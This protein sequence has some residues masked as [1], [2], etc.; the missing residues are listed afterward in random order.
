M[1]KKE[2][3]EYIN[4]AIEAA[5]DDNPVTREQLVMELIPMGVKISTAMH[6]IT[7]AFKKAGIITAPKP[8]ALKEVKEWLEKKMPEIDTYRDMRLLAEKL[9]EKFEVNDDDE[10]AVAAIIK[11]IQ[12][13]LK[14]EELPIPRR[15]NLGETKALTLDYFQWCDDEDE[16]ATKDGL[17]EYLI[18]NVEGAGENA[19]EKVEKALTVTAGTFFN[20]IYLA[21]NHL[22]VD[23]LN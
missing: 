12:A 19:T 20:F 18:A 8:S 3:A 16:S 10:K 14:E 5:T 9:N 6:A 2:I 22:S 23:E 1:K 13:Q 7:K 15:I 4:A 21:W 17:A 11:A